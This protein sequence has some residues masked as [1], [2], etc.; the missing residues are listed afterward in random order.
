MK[1]QVARGIEIV[2]E[3]EQAKE[4]VKNVLLGVKNATKKMYRKA[5]SS[6]RGRPKGS[7]NKKK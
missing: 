7:K 5:K 6:G 4:I 1:I 2:I 3:D